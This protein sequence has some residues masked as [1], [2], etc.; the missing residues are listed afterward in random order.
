MNTKKQTDKATDT[1]SNLQ[2]AQTERHKI[3]HVLKVIIKNAKQE[4]INE[5][6]DK[7]NSSLEEGD[8]K[9]AHAYKKLI[10]K[11]KSTNTWKTIKRAL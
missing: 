2:E 1:T 10:E 11:E 6:T 5:I 7:I 4:R 3:W 8:H 9:A